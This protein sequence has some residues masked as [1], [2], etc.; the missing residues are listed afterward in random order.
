MLR[1][2]GKL[3]SGFVDLELL[4]IHMFVEWFFVCVDCEDVAR[5]HVNAQVSRELVAEHRVATDN[6][7][8]LVAGRKRR[9]SFIDRRELTESPVVKQSACL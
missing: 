9:L 7:H 4:V 1:V 2:E 6:K 3:A 8:S 5:R